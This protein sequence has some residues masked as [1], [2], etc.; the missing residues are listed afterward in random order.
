MCT[1]YKAY[2]TF[3]YTVKKKKTIHIIQYKTCI[4]EKK[5]ISAAKRRKRE[6]FFLIRFDSIIMYDRAFIEF[7]VTTIAAI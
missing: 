3:R 1:A 2:I 7:R 6:F 4:I 5:K